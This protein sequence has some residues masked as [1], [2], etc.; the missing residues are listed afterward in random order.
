VT[1]LLH[2]I[3][4]ELS[5][6]VDVL[7]RAE[8][9]AE[10]GVYSARIGDFDDAREAVRLLRERFGSANV[11]VS[12]WIMLI[13]GLVLFFESLS[14]IAYDR[15]R[16]ANLVGRASEN[17]DLAALTAAWLAHLD[18]NA[19]RF[20]DMEQWL[21]SCLHKFS[22]QRSDTRIRVYVVVAS[23]CLYAGYVPEGRRFCELAR[24]EAVAVG[25][26]ATLSA[27]MY[28]RAA[29]TL[30]YLRV[31]A[32]LGR[33][34]PEAAEFLEMEVASAHRFNSA[35][36][37]SALA[38][39]VDLARARL[40]FF[41]CRYAAAAEILRTQLDGDRPLGIKSGRALVELEYAVCMAQLGD[42]SAANALDT[43]ADLESELATEERLIY[44][45]L[46]GVLRG[47]IDV[48]PRSIEG[49]RSGLQ[50]IYVGDTILI[51]RC[52]RL[53]RDALDG[54]H[55]WPQ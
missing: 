24:R 2:R 11:R 3:D 18:F 1:T 26:E 14:T 9:I 19:S 7:R 35:V 21:G 50:S 13:E 33:E 25:D 30:T 42:T 28:N 40:E 44:C 47:L 37:H 48:E 41:K 5:S 15:I 36:K 38:H 32:A 27:I 16:R 34:D 53:V 55:L 43:E 51:R 46:L 45:H 8:L 29:L 20:N 4:F 31:C 52:L 22:E 39:I 23:A 10:R 54:E 6:C 17:H 49:E 12:I